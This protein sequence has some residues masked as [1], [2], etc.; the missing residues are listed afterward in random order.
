VDKSLILILAFIHGAFPH[1]FDF[2]GVAKNGPGGTTN[3]K[4]A[5]SSLAGRT[6]W[7]QSLAANL[8]KHPEPLIPRGTRFGTYFDFASLDQPQ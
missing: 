8:L 4:A 3:Q 2:Y 7:N 6:L 5:S 1:L